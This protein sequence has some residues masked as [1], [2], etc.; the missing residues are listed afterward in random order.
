VPRLFVAVQPPADVLAGIAALERRDEP[1]VR[2]VSPEQWHVTVRFLGEAPL[3][4]AI[5]ALDAAR[6]VLLGLGVVEAEVGP[7]VARL[8]RHVVC[9]PV[10]GLDGVAAAVGEATAAVGQP[11]DPRPFRGHVTLA[12][13]QQRAACGLAGQRFRARFPVS[14]VVLVRSVLGRGG[15]RHEPV[16]TVAFG[17][18]VP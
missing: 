3:E 1:G 10:A 14:E 12:R 6:P 7:Q 13:L 9:L 4:D 17:R 8:G 16:H 5:A 2:W 15:A 11:P 18:G